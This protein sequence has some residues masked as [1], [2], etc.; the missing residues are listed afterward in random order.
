MSLK[1][2]RLEGMKPGTSDP[3]A[4]VFPGGEKPPKGKSPADPEKKREELKNVACPRAVAGQ[5]CKF[6]DEGKC[7]YSHSKKLVGKA[8]AEPKPKAKSAP[9]AKAKSEAK[10]SGKKEKDCHFFAKGICR[11]GDKCDYK[12]EV[13][14]D[15]KS[16]EPT[17]SA[18]TVVA[19]VTRCAAV[20]TFAKQKGGQRH[21]VGVGCG[22]AR[23]NTSNHF[24]GSSAETRLGH[25]EKEGAC[26][27]SA[28]ARLGFE[29]LGKLTTTSTST[30]PQSKVDEELEAALQFHNS[31]AV[32]CPAARFEKESLGKGRENYSTGA[33]NT[34]HVF[35]SSR[36]PDCE[37]CHAARLN[38]APAQRH[39]ADHV[40]PRLKTYKFGD[41]V[42]LDTFFLNIRADGNL[43]AVDESAQAIM[44][45]VFED[46]H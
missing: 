46:E 4:P 9:A 19:S 34:Y 5:P 29:Q 35:A 7:Y 11:N 25:E 37:L 17:A 41:M 28:E 45:Q 40:D 12:H 42:H 43:E 39:P 2:S 38:E 18:T 14:E 24:A 36:K 23:S 3:V 8:K 31:V 44:L 1:L 26:C 22:G 20:A 13:A 32:A 30:T 33:K 10:P 6:F 27:S 16:Q 15:S 21:K